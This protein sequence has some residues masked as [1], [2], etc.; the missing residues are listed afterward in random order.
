MKMFWNIYQR[1][2]HSYHLAIKINEN[3]IIWK[4]LNRKQVLNNIMFFLEFQ[5]QIS[6][7][8]VGLQE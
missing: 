5:Y 4:Y 8:V 1:R 3:K 6:Q 7:N 2:L